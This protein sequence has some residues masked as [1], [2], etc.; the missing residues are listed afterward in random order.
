MATVSELFPN[1]LGLRASANPAEAGKAISFY[2]SAPDFYATGSRR[3]QYIPS[4]TVTFYD[5]STVIGAAPLPRFGSA[6][7]TVGS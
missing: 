4:G 6:K 1:G 3:Y 7:V 2:G 5:G